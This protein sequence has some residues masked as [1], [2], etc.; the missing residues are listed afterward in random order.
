MF[1]VLKLESYGFYKNH[2][3]EALDS[4]KGDVDQ[5]L[6]LLYSKYFPKT[7]R[8]GTVSES[9]KS[10]HSREDINEMRQDEM[11]ALQSIYESAF[12][13]QVPNEVWQLKFK[14]DHLLLHSPYEQKKRQEAAKEAAKERHGGKKLEKCRNLLKGHCK[15]G[16]HCRYSHKVDAEKADKPYDS[17]I[18]P[19]WFYLEV[20]F[21]KENIYPY[22]TPL[23]FLKTTC[24]DI[25]HMLCLRI[26]RRI[27]E[28]AREMAK[29]EM[30]S[31]YAI[32]D[33]LQMNE[34]IST[35]LK[36][37][38]YQFLDAK[39]SLFYVSAADMLADNEEHE[40]LPTHYAKGCRF[41]LYS[42]LKQF[43]VFFFFFM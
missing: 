20:R 30:S 2:C 11:L 29:N 17:N 6:E 26:T 43:Y 14:I 15:Y 35:F 1:A 39:K 34:E 42:T 32:A 7:K 18:D 8:S 19:N 40:D 10:E 33:L 21:P 16:N 23:V 13:E 3:V 22:E 9:N 5:S 25:P 27:V 36:N 28:E 38:R 31:I 37:D 24:P 41:T 12:E 4:C